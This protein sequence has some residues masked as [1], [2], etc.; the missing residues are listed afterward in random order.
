M[1]SGLYYLYNIVEILKDV[2]KKSHCGHQKSLRQHHNAANWPR[3]YGA[4][5]KR[6][7]VF[8]TNGVWCKKNTDRGVG[9]H[10]APPEGPE[11]GPRCSWTEPSPSQCSSGGGG[12][13]L[14]HT[15]TEATVAGAAT[16][17]GAAAAQPKHAPR[18]LLCCLL[19]LDAELTARSLG[20]IGLIESIWCQL[21]PQMP[22]RTASARKSI[23]Q[24]AHVQWT[25]T[26]P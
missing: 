11:S 2:H 21:P 12:R 22:N 10:G 15:P 5:G 25:H 14:L 16:P 7:I 1:V 17:T 9:E 4:E 18:P 13:E 19:L 20:L 24:N 3:F 26:V 6:G 8:S 23:A